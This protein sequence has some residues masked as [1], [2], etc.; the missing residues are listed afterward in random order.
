MTDKQCRD[1]LAGML[2][3][4]MIPMEVEAELVRFLDKCLDAISWRSAEQPPKL[5]REVYE[6]EEESVEYQISDRVLGFTEEGEMVAVYYGDVGFE[7][8][9]FDMDGA[10]YRITHWRPLPVPPKEVDFNGKE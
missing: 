4:S 5:R 9:W 6:D 10:T 3:V 2:S 1:K 8:G 7:L